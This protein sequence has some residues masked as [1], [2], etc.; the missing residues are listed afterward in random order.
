MYWWIHDWFP[1]APGAPLLSPAPSP[2]P[3]TYA[4]LDR[5]RWG[6]DQSAPASPDMGRR[7]AS[8]LDVQNSKSPNSKTSVGRTV[9]RSRTPTA[10]RAGAITPTSNRQLPLPPIGARINGIQSQ[11]IP[12]RSNCL[13]LSYTNRWPEVAADASLCRWKT[14]L[15]FLDFP[16]QNLPVH[17]LKISLDLIRNI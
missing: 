7:W 5:R 1:A 17:S 11:P 10:S 13:L 12:Q 8:M 4:S 16:I 9:P 14:S 6:K 15:T 3:S 2:V